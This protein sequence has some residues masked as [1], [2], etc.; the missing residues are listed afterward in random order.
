MGVADLLGQHD[1][2]RI[3]I[4]VSASPGD[5]AARVEHD[6]V[7]A[8]AAPGESGLS[9]VTLVGVIGISITLRVTLTTYT[10]DEPCISS[11]LIV[12]WFE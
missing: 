3:A 1:H 9:L 8:G 7:G 10:A 5:F 6:A 4:D 2:N 12:Q 11:Q